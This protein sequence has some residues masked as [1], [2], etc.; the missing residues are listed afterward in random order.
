MRAA[1]QHFRLRPAHYTQLSP[2]CCVPSGHILAPWPIYSGLPPTSCCYASN[3]GGRRY[4]VRQRLTPW[5][6][7]HDTPPECLRL[8]RGGGGRTGDLICYSARLGIV[9]SFLPVMTLMSC[10]MLQMRQGGYLG[11]RRKPHNEDFYNYTL[12]TVTRVLGPRRHLC[13]KQPG[14][15][16]SQTTSTNVVGSCVFLSNSDYSSLLHTQSPLF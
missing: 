5:S 14:K 1:A 12:G 9:P 11:P 6:R 8:T 2:C 10:L 4:L 3:S 16:G 15:P 13:Q 7:S